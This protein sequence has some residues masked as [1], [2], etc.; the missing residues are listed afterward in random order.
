MVKKTWERRKAIKLRKEG[1]TYS[2]ILN[3]VLVAKSTLGLWLKGVKLS[4]PQ[5]QKFTMQ[6]RLASL[7][8]G[9]VKREIRIEKQKKIS[10]MSKI[11]VGTL[12]KREIFLIGVALYWAEGTKEKEYHPGSGVAF[13]N[14]DA[15]IISIFIRW[16]KVICKTPK[17]MIGFEIM[18]HK[19]HKHRLPEIKRFWSRITGFP[20]RSFSK[21]YIKNNKI[22][23]TK[24][25]NVGEKYHGVLK[26]GVKRSSELVRKIAGWSEAIFEN[27]K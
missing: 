22:K 23:K 24:R 17:N 8:G 6:K 2:E 9:Q 21:V 1:K 16:L 27:Y 15:K 3:A 19:S 5:Q 26:V 7:R 10:A 12:S 4:K 25:R 11:D 14:M 20:T 13:S 18:V